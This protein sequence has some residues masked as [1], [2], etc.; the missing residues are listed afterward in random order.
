M[1]NYDEYLKDLKDKAKTM[2]L[3][4]YFDEFGRSMDI[5]EMWVYIN[6]EKKLCS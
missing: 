5:Y 4:E 2:T 3:N 1:S 6:K